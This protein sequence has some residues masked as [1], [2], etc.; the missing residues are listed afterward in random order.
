VVEDQLRNRGDATQE[1]R[2]DLSSVLLTPCC[3]WPMPLIEAPS[4]VGLA[5]TWARW[6]AYR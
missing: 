5:Q 4:H 1:S 3:S 6:R 2:R